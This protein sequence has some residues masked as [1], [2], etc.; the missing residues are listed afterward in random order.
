[1]FE[2]Y[3]SLVGWYVK[4][5]VELST[6]VR[7]PMRVLSYIL[8]NGVLLGFQKIRQIMGTNKVNVQ[9]FWINSGV[10]NDPNFVVTDAGSN[11]KWGFILNWYFWPFALISKNTANNG[12]K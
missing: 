6:L 9:E 12:Y 10:V 1:M 11:P 5:D 8:N 7:V 2:N 4:R 3:G